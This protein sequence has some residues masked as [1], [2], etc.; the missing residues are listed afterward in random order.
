M[1]MS[2]LITFSSYS[3][4][5]YPRPY[6]NRWQECGMLAH[7]YQVTIW[8]SSQR[9][10]SI[11]LLAMMAVFCG[12]LYG[13]C[14]F[15]CLSTK[16]LREFFYYNEWSQANFLFLESTRP[17]KEHGYW[18]RIDFI[19]TL[20]KNSSCP[21]PLVYPCGATRVTSSELGIFR[22]KPDDIQLLRAVYQVT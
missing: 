4:R 13:L 11:S 12:I 9:K 5:L 8:H 20:K 1:W 16:A 15:C 19:D 6:D 21:I 2:A 7:R 10:C 17:L 14:F 22:V 3:V 18:H